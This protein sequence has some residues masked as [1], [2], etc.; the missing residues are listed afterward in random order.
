[1]KIFGHMS[2]FRS[3]SRTSIP[4][5]YFDLLLFHPVHGKTRSE[6]TPKITKKGLKS[7]QH[8]FY[9]TFLKVSPKNKIVPFFK[10]KNEEKLE[11]IFFKLFF[12][13]KTVFAIFEK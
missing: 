9:F 2:S 7:A 5:F 10:A 12:R 4:K 3:C 8:F 13:S 1:M 11:K 6:E